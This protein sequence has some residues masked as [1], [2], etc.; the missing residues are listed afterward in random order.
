MS[1]YINI[2][3]NNIFYEYIK[4]LNI[5]FTQLLKEAEFNLYS[6]IPPIKDANVKS[7]DKWSILIHEHGNQITIE[8][9]NIIF[10]Y[11][12]LTYYL[13]QLFGTSK[14]YN[15]YVINPIEYI[16][17]LPD[18]WKKLNYEQYKKLTNIITAF[19][20]NNFKID[21][22]NYLKEDGN[23]VITNQLLKY[24]KTK[25]KNKNIWKKQQDTLDKIIMDYSIGLDFND[26]LK[27]IEKISNINIIYE[28]YAYIY[29]QYD[30]DK[31][32]YQIN[33]IDKLNNKLKNIEL[34][35]FMNN[36]KE[37]MSN[38]KE[39]IKFILQNNKYLKKN[40]ICDTLLYKNSEL[41]KLGIIYNRLKVMVEKIGKNYEKY[42]ESENNSMLH[43][44]K[45][46]QES[47]KGVNY[48]ILDQITD[49]IQKFIYYSVYIYYHNYKCITKNN[50]INYF[51]NITNKF[52]NINYKINYIKLC[53]L[54]NPFDDDS[55]YK[56][57]YNDYV[58]L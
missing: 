42:K 47:Y 43:M 14:L 3:N 38:Y 12:L 28:I 48:Y 9:C 53:D 19:K 27:Q 6:E 26:F 18:D 46:E 40:T 32:T 54:I 23:D 29:K 5:S 49:E 1:R 35:N 58:I 50:V 55:L 22:Y 57:D 56:I 25:Y 52:K 39:N 13:N 4:K 17:S 37:Y 8:S 24:I 36:N 34:K 16:N 33:N 30:G 41:L 44:I 2:I 15:I 20:I 21:N 10:K 45:E 7:I 11:G 51:E 31:F